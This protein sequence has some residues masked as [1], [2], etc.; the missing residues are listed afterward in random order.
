MDA[1]ELLLQASNDFSQENPKSPKKTDITSEQIHSSMLGIL[2]SIFL[3]IDFLEL[4]C[5]ECSLDPIDSIMMLADQAIKQE[6]ATKQPWNDYGPYFSQMSSQGF[7]R[8]P[9][10][11]SEP[12]TTHDSLYAALK[13][14]SPLATTNERS[15][16]PNGT[17]GGQHSF[18]NLE[19]T[20]PHM[21]DRYS[22]I[23]NK[24][25]RVGIYTRE[26]RNAI[27]NRFHEKRKRRVWKKKIRYFCRKNLA[28]RRVR[29]KGR[30]VKAAGGMKITANGYVSAA[31]DVLQPDQDARLVLKLRRGGADTTTT[32][33]SAVS[34]STPSTASNSD[35]VVMNETDGEEE[36]GNSPVLLN[37]NEEEEEVSSAE[38]GHS[39]RESFA[40][41]RV[42]GSRSA[43]DGELPGT[44]QN[45]GNAGPSNVKLFFLSSMCGEYVDEGEDEEEVVGD[46][47]SGNHMDTAV[48]AGADEEND[49][50]PD[51]KKMRRHS[52]AY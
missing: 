43:T 16:S 5:C 22:S 25:G 50:L 1:F 44:T 34:T 7:E 45:D 41:A 38:E 20:L 24:G 17:D 33:S 28:D 46:S 35:D 2:S 12:W 18:L 36:G 47:S 11:M 15:F 48:G 9:R 4:F 30:F 10:A 27:I 40:Q 52:I 6:S 13:Y 19:Q 3:S 31:G 42:A 8:K 29:V 21:L 49:R 37:R 51:G 23:Y 32:S 39:D 14:V 26:E